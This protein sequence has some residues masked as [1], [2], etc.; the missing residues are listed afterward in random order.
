M[1]IYVFQIFNLIIFRRITV[2]SPDYSVGEIPVILM[3]KPVF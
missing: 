1:Y 3:I 2:I